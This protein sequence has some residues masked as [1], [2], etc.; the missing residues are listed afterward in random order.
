MNYEIKITKLTPMPTAQY[1]V[2]VKEG[3][4]ESRHVVDVPA[5]YVTKLG[6]SMADGDE[7]G[8]EDLLQRSFAFLLER[9]PKESILKQ[10]TLS[11]IERYFPEYR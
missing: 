7:K 5:E 10:F 1:E 4:S 11:D 8:I 6:F 9:E 2:V 3:E